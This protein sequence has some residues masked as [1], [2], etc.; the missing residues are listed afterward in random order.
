MDMRLKPKTI[1]ICCYV[2]SSVVRNPGVTIDI[3]ISHSDKSE[4]EM[5]YLQIVKNIFIGI[6]SLNYAQRL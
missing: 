4:F 2:I 6:P 5:T 1:S 3:Q